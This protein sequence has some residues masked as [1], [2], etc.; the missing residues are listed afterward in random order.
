[1][2]P[3]AVTERIPQPKPAV[4][5]QLLQFVEPADEKRPGGHTPLHVDAVMAV[6]TPNDPAA[7]GL[8]DTSPARLYV[9]TPHAL[10]GGADVTEPGGHAY[11]ATHSD[12]HDA[13]SATALLNRPALQ[14]VHSDE[15]PTE[16]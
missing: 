16:Y 14:L 13:P 5:V 6:P 11:P 4:A 7:Q 1:M 15:P 10:D 8:H 2:E 9:P 3:A 12:V